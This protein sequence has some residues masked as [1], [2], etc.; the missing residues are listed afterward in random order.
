MAKGSL[1]VA[2]YIGHLNESNPQESIVM[3]FFKHNFISLSW[4]W[5]LK[6]KTE[7]QSNL[8]Y[9]PADIEG[10][11][12]AAKCCE[13]KTKLKG[14]FKTDTMTESLRLENTS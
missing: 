5:K 2:K 10:N 8:S 13:K 9:N 1:T 6:N 4:S 11:K 7:I 14:C 12:Q 3:L